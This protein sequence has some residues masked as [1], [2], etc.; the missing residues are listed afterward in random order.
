MWAARILAGP[1]MGTAI[2]STSTKDVACQLL[3][4]H[5]LYY[6]L[7]L[8]SVPRT[9]FHSNSRAFGISF[10]QKMMIGFFSCDWTLANGIATLIVLSMCQ[11]FPNTCVFYNF[12]LFPEF[13]NSSVGSFRGFR[14]LGFH[15]ADCWAF[16]FNWKMYS[17]FT[18]KLKN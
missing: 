13:N 11:L 9:N 5:H 7:N 6:K 10:L 18:K 16:I 12:F 15:W 8:S 14:L 4:F 3:S 17:P 2:G 1:A